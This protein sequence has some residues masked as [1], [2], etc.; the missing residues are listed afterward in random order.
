VSET[1]KCRA[2]LTYTSHPRHATPHS[3]IVIG[4]C[5]KAAGHKGMH[6]GQSQTWPPPT[7]YLERITTQ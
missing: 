2:K 4:I 6:S 3:P 7:R 1:P 5:E